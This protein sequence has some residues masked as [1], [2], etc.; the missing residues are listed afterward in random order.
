MALMSMSRSQFSHDELRTLGYLINNIK[1]G[2]FC[3]EDQITEKIALLERYQQTLKPA[4]RQHF[5][6]VASTITKLKEDKEILAAD[7]ARRTAILRVEQDQYR[8]PAPV[9]ENQIKRLPEHRK[10]SY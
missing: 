10:M 4:Q 5:N 2:E 1:T 9:I 6:L 3:T 7:I 8:I